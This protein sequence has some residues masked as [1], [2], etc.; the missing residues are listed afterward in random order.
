MVGRADRQAGRGLAYDFFRFVSRHLVGDPGAGKSTFAAQMA[1]PILVVDADHRFQEVARLS[2]GDIY[3]V[4]TA[5][6]EAEA[7]A[8]ELRAKESDRVNS[9]T[10]EL[11]KLGA[12]VEPTDESPRRA[13]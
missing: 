2:A 7:I 11:R 12:E 4:D 3:T 10:T 6:N 9:V 13:E 8:A 5:G 1:G